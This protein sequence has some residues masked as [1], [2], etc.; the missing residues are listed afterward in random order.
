V[1]NEPVFLYLSL[2]PHCCVF[3]C[4]CFSHHSVKLCCMLFRSFCLFHSFFSVFFFYCVL[5]VY[6]E[7]DKEHVLFFPCFSWDPSFCRVSNEQTHCA[8]IYNIIN[9]AVFMMLLL[10]LLVCFFFLFCSFCHASFVVE[11]YFSLVNKW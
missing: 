9:Y 3:I 8:I 6:S 1:Q 5:L 4:N 10:F 2:V 7:G 11:Y